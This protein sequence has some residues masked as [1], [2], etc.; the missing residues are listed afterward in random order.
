MFRLVLVLALLDPTAVTEV[1]HRNIPSDKVLT[2]DG[3]RLGYA[4]VSRPFTGARRLTG[5]LVG[6]DPVTGTHL[7]CG[8][9]VLGS[10]SRSL[11]LTAAHCLYHEGRLLRQLAFLPAYDRGSPPLGVWPAVRTWA[12]ARWRGRSYS[13]ELLPYDVGLVGVATAARRSLEDVTGPG[14]RP[15]ATGKGTALRGLE[16]LG[17][18]KGKQYPGTRMY[19]CVGDAVEGTVRGPGVLVTRNCHAA[20]GGS[21]GPAVY[22]QEVAGVVSSSSP[23]KDAKGFTV[24]TRLGGK[25]F[26]RMYHEADRAMRLR[27]ASSP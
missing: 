15:L 17:Y 14:L 18:P 10:R 19:R 1:S 20:A 7:M 21:G 2:P 8:G 3:D 11:V 13:A 25:S 6:R 22:G 16:L 5:V 26:T 9:T 4:P 12:P 27:Q 24:V 23:L